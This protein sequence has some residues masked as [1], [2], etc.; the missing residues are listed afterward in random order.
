MKTGHPKTSGGFVQ[1]APRIAS[2]GFLLFLS[3]FSLDVFEP[4]RS[5]GEIALGLLMHNIPVFVLAVLTAAAWKRPIIGGITFISA[6]ILYIAL[7]FLGGVRGGIDWKIAL[8]WSVQLSGI[9]F[10]VGGLYIAGWKRSR[11]RRRAESSS[12]LH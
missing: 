3:L 1:W 9:A 8:L 7:V 6:G 11:D 10:L 12:N 2:I 5:A 4:G